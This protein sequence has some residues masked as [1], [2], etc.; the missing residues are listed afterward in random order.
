MPS[1]ASVWRA[2]PHL[3][4]SLRV[5]GVRKLAYHL[6]FFI[7][8]LVFTIFPI[9]ESATVD[10]ADEDS[11]FQKN[12]RHDASILRARPHPQDKGRR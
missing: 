7:F 3:S 8:R 6:Q 11:E 5:Q 9:C 12:V 1:L 10:Y 2:Y 4:N